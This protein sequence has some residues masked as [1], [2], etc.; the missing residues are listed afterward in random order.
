M[1]T[2]LPLRTL[3]VD[4]EPLATERLQMVCATLPGIVCIGTASDGEAALRMVAAL[5]PDLLLLD[6]AMPGLDGIGVARTLD[7]QPRP[8]AII[9]CTAFQDHALAA[10]EVAAADYLLKPVEPARL[11]RAIE[12][13]RARSGVAVPAS[14]WLKELWVPYRSE[15]LRI[16]IDEVDRIGA[17]RD[18]MR[19]YVGD[20]SF[21]IHQ[22]LS[23]LES[24]L[25][26]ARFIRLHRSTVVRRAAIEA[27]RHDGLGVWTARL[28][29]GSDVRVARSYLNAVKAIVATS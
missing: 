3:I 20:R 17:E 22:T 11:E 14:P 25:D 23:G 12:R 19:L 21:L 16:G 9:F 8:P 5:S 1:A 18:Y 27:L 15:M 7:A 28:R 6:I 29:D 10:F 4:D 2:D 24:R 13:V 26:P